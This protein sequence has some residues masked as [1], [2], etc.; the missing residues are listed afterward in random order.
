MPPLYRLLFTLILSLL[1]LLSIGAARG[2]LPHHQ[3]QITLQPDTG[4]L[5]AS[6]RLTLPHPVN[7]LDFTLH[8]GLTPRVEESRFTLTATRRQTSGQVPLQRYRITSVTPFSQVTLHYQGDIRHALGSIDDDYSSSRQSTPGLISAEG[9]FLSSGSF[10]YPLMD[11]GMVTFDMT[12]E[13]PPGWSSVSQGDAHPEGDGWSITQPQDE[14]Y[15]IAAPYHRYQRQGAIAEAQVYLRQDDPAL[16]GRYLD[17]T[18]HY[19]ELYH[20]LLGPYP[21]SKFALVENFWE[22]GYGMPSF[23]L[24]GP[25]VIRLPFILHSSYPHEILHNWWGNGV[26]VDYSSGNWSEGLT[27]YL[28]DHLIKEQRGEGATYRRGTLQRYS[29]YVDQQEEIPLTAFRSRHGQSSQAVGYGKTLMLFHML[30]S[31]LGDRQFIEGLR[32]FYHQQLFHTAGFSQLKQAFEAV[33]GKPLGPFF[34]QW[35][36][37][38]GAPSLTLKSPRVS[39]QDGHYRLTA[40]LLQSQASPPFSLQLPLFIETEG[41]SELKQLLLRM[42]DRELMIDIELEYAPVRLAIDPRFDLFR[43]LDPSEIPS[44]LGQL[45]GADR[46]TIILPVKV[47]DQIKSAYQQLAS[48]WRQ[49]GGDIEIVWDSELKQLPADRSL[50]LFGSEN[51]FAGEFSHLPDEL[52][53]DPAANSYALTRRHPKSPSLTIGLL[54]AASLDALPGLARKLPHYGKYSYTLFDGS[55]PDIRLKGEWPLSTSALTVDLQPA[56]QPA[57]RLPRHRPLSEIGQTHPAGAP[58]SAPH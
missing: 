14:I 45:F 51:R 29:D 25:Q 38:T 17:A 46:L 27:S 30:R 44:S 48:A 58:T 47:A 39:R 3:M 1:P 7:Q 26:Y 11:Q 56:S 21:Y 5:T 50:W 2:E 16:A 32:R 37:R 15:L 22:S 31:E 28:A 23:T 10:W 42:D 35:T 52:V 41:A 19:L 34:Q 55:N 13:L 18:E 20:G 40:R 24:L 8:Q 36:E 6:D 43:R 4:T 57:I 33:S 12:I 54:S 53:I 49:R 9:V